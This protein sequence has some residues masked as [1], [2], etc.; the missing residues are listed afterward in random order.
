MSSRACCSCSAVLLDPNVNHSTTTISSHIA[1][2]NESQQPLSSL[3]EIL[4]SANSTGV[5]R[6]LCEYL[7]KITS[8]NFAQI[9]RHAKELI[10]E[11]DVTG[12][13]KFLDRL[14]Q[15]SA[16][17]GRAHLVLSFDYDDH[18]NTVA[19]SARA[20]GMDIH[21]LDCSKESHFELIG[22]DFL[23]VTLEK[24]LSGETGE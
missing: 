14:G 19:L 6:N 10:A 24:I 9:Q 16:R 13:D 18:F 17:V 20:R 12:Y 21:K 23:K 5:F 15:L 7:Y 8:K 22:A 11:L 2:M 3:A 1:A 4:A